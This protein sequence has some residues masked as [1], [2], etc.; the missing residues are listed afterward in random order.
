[1]LS[2][3]TTRQVTNDEKKPDSETTD[4]S[5]EAEANSNES[6]EPEEKIVENCHNLDSKDKINADS[7]S[8]SYYSDIFN[9]R[10]KAN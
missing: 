8:L 6:Y 7:Q 10:K 2:T 9:Q 3:C 1:M 5:S 4:M